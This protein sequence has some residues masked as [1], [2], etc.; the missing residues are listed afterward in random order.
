M[1][2]V[3]PPRIWA[4]APRSGPRT[5]GISD[6]VAAGTKSENALGVGVT[7]AMSDEVVHSM[8]HVGWAGSHGHS[9]KCSGIGATR[10]REIAALRRVRHRPSLCGDA[11]GGPTLCGDA[12]G[13]PSAALRL[14]LRLRLRPGPTA[15]SRRLRAPSPEPG[16]TA[17]N[18]AAG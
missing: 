17:R 11:A 7:G 2:A 18:S 5:A 16:V 10:K 13:S 4:K 6:E 15:R 14:R 8:G 12:G 3:V 1:P 9:R